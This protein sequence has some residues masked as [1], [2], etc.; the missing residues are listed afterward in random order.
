[1]KVCRSV[2]KITALFLSL[3]VLFSAQTV[4]FA[5]EYNDFDYITSHINFSRYTS[6]QIVRPAQQI[7]VN[8]DAYY[9]AGA[10][11]PNYDL[12][13]DGN[14]VSSRGQLGSFGIYVALDQGKN[15]FEFTQ[16]NGAYAEVVIIRGIADTAATTEIIS[17]MSPSY[18]IVSY[19]GDTM[20]LSC[21]A[22]SG[23]TVTASVGGRTYTLKQVAATA[24]TGV[25]ATFQVAVEAPNAGAA[26]NIG[27]V[28]YVLSYGGKQTSY[29][30]KGSIYAAGANALVAVKV[31]N[32]V[33]SIYKDAQRS[34]YI[35]TGKQNG[36]D[37]IVDTSKEMYKL[38]S[39]GWVYKESMQPM[40]GQVSIKN[41]VSE[42]GYGF[43]DNSGARTGE[44]YYLTGT[45][46]PMFTAWKDNEKLYVKLYNTTGVGNASGWVDHSAL[47]SS[48]EA[49]EE[50]GH[51]IL[52][53]MLGGS[54]N[55]WGYDISYDGGVTTIYAK[56]RP[57]KNG[58]QPLSGIRI[59]V[60]AGHGGTDPGAIGI[61]GTKAAM[62]KDIVLQTSIALQKRLE[63]LGATVVM[64]RS[65]DLDMTMDARIA[66]TLEHDCDFFISLHANSIGFVQRSNE[67]KGVE[68]YYYENMSGTLAKQIAE[69]VASYTGRTARGAKHANYRVT[70]NTFAPSVLVEMGFLTNPY[71]YDNMLSRRGIFNTVNAIGDSIIAALG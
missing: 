42:L 60:D 30:S 16:P 41:K 26:Q 20:T 25:P 18:D 40:E 28:T 47:F 21:T 6:L 17:S 66:K 32:S 38:S 55:L 19:A 36:T 24:Q 54:N 50:N 27:P 43:N 5:A 23:A 71:D 49:T 7:T 57:V 51:T 61:Q 69:K 10:S 63:S 58:S 59:A 64:M 2:R 53:F 13:M 44:Y 62:E 11:D 8:A 29:Q 39:G 1:M 14:L 33:T 56:Y 35:E 15:V 48:V 9:I 67:A 52:K 4:A 31:K 3:A 46:N 68:V 37:V 12:Y 45:S 22:P 65:D 34:A 70:L